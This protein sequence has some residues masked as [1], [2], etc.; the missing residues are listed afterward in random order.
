MIAPLLPIVLMFLAASAAFSAWSS[1]RWRTRLRARLRAEWGRPR[2]RPRDMDAVADF[3]R[4]HDAVGGSLDDRTVYWHA[5][6]PLIRERPY[7]GWGLNVGSR[8]VLTSLGDNTVS[9]IHSTWIEALLGTG[10]TGAAFLALAFL[11]ALGAAWRVRRQ[12]VGVAV[13]GMLVFFC[14]RSI[15]GPTTELFDLGFLLFGAFICVAD[16]LR[17]SEGNRQFAH[18]P[19]VSA[20]T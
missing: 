16:Q 2:D 8:R 18:R 15:T 3:F 12:P 17:L 13:L 20:A 1:W 9:T 4:S 7:L 19:D 10:F 11:T 5:S 6:K 14:V